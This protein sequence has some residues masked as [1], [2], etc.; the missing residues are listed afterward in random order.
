M[1]SPYVTA[2]LGPLR[3]RMISARATSRPALVIYLTHGDP[4]P[5]ETVDIIEAAVRGGADVIELGVPFSDPSADGPVIQAA[6]ERALRAGGGR[7][8]ALDTIAELRTRRCYVPIVLFGYYNPI[9][10]YGVERFAADAASV[11]VDAVL[12]VDLPFE[13]LDELLGP[14]AERDVGVIPLLAPT[15]TE[16]RLA[17]VAALAPPFVYY[18]SMTGVT[19]ATLAGGVGLALRIS[20]IRRVTGAAVAVGFGIKTPADAVAIASMADA[21]VV[22]SAVVQRIAE[23]APGTAPA[24]VERFVAELKAALPR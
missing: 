6:M 13:E 23:A 17:R 10:V 9:F 7:A 5:A 19:G 21:V 2:E 11:G 15:S 3:Q 1:K 14:L 8:G 20:D 16:D 4:S 18:I 12:T 24:A 22:G